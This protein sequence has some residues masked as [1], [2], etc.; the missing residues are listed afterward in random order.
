MSRK[1]LL[2][3]LFLASASFLQ[4]Q[5]APEA[6]SYVKQLRIG[7]EY[8][9]VNPDYGQTHRLNGA[10]G[11]ADYDWV[12]MHAVLGLEADAHFS[13]DPLHGHPTES[14]F[15]VG[16]RYGFRFAKKIITPYVRIGIG[17]GNFS[18][19]SSLPGQNG[20]HF[21]MAAAGGVDIRVTRRISVRAL[22]YEP[23]RWNFVPHS[24]SP[25]VVSIGASFRW[26]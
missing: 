21:L 2:L 11:Y 5:V 17:L 22:D 13:V 4:A 16:P 15:I 1:Y 7:G 24:L 9:R 6:Y 26:H 23:Q 3:S 19:S 12:A 20:V 25:N 18:L 10:S 8:S 14:S